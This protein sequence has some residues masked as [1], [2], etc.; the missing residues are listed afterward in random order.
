M[1]CLSRFKISDQKK[2]NTLL[3]LL[4]LHY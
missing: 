2:N 3:L 4:Q 1:T